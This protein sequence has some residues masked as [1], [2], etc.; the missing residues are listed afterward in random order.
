MNTAMWIKL[1]NEGIALSLLIGLGV[2]L[3]RGFRKNQI[4]L[5]E[6]EDLLKRYI[7]FR[8]DKQARL[9]VYGEDEKVY[10]EILRTL[11]TSWKNFKK[12]YDQC[13]LSFAQNTARTR[14][15]LQLITL[16]LL[17]NSARLLVEE[18]YFY[19]LQARF[20][21]TTVRE[22]SG[23]VLVSVSFFLLRAQTHEILSLKGNAVKMEREALF[24]PNSPSAEREKEGLYN[25]FDP[26]EGIGAENGKEDQDRHR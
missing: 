13:L 2:I 17:A 26:L 7:L 23:Y 21:Y 20:L 25:E 4:L 22:L 9:Q 24:F 8:G 6:R 1:L 16:G 10:Q 19:G 5:S 3:Y 15:L 12:T 11:S 14:L 18:Y